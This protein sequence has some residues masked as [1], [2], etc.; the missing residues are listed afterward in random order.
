MP[1][2]SLIFSGCEP[3]FHDIIEITLPLDRA[4]LYRQRLDIIETT[5]ELISTKL[6]GKIFLFLYANNNNNN[7]RKTVEQTRNRGTSRQKRGIAL[8]KDGQQ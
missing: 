7:S 6:S 8:R 1:M 3:S 5:R 4:F 2:S